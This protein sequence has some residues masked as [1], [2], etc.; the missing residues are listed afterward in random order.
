[1]KHIGVEKAEERDVFVKNL[2]KNRLFV[3]RA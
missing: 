1:M 3:R 2:R